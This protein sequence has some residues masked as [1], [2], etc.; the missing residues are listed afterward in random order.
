MNVTITGI[1]DKVMYKEEN[2][3]TY[4]VVI[5][6]KTGNPDINLN[7]TIYGINMQLPMY[8]YLLKEKGDLK[9]IEV[10]GFYYQKY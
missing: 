5:D 7:N 4:L 8:L 1:I 6:Y 2:N 9:E 10:S 3:H